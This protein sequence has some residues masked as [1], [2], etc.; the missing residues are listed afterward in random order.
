ML[1]FADA[2]PS[3]LNHFAIFCDP[4]AL[5]GADWFACVLSARDSD[6]RIYIVDTYSVNAGSREQIARHLRDWM[7]SY[8]VERC[9]IETNG[10]IGIDFF[11]FCV[12]SGLPVEGWYSKGNKFDR[13]VGCY[14]ALCDEVTFIR[15]PRLDDYMSQVYLFDSKCEHDDNIDAVVSSYR[16]QKYSM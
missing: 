7:A 12:N 5:R 1:T 15:N 2:E 4:S 13:I 8:D 14:Q 9:Y 11:E 3:G 10:I 16:A 6:G